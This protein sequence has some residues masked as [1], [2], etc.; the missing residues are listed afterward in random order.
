MLS[1]KSHPVEGIPKRNEALQGNVPEAL[2]TSERL[3]HFDHITEAKRKQNEVS[4]IKSR[5]EKTM[6][7]LRDELET[8]RDELT[9]CT[10][11]LRSQKEK[12][13]ELER[14]V[15]LCQE[16]IDISRDKIVVQKLEEQRLR[17]RADELSK[18]REQQDLQTRE[19][20]DRVLKLRTWCS[21]F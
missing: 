18:S 21:R 6:S 20:S 11:N 16:E 13:E 19:L 15:S 17:V 12:L 1:L 10:S 4:E 8:S 3:A 5:H 2:G 7:S 14:A 9:M